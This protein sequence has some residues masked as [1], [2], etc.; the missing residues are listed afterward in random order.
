MSRVDDKNEERRAEEARAAERRSQ[1]RLQRE[2]RA[3]ITAFD[4]A[5]AA[6]APP[7]RGPPTRGGSGSSAFRRALLGDPREAQPSEGEALEGEV[8]AEE[9]SGAASPKAPEGAKA[10][11]RQGG[12]QA[13]PSSA[14]EGSPAA[15]LRWRGRGAPPPPDKYRDASARRTDSET[16]RA[17]VREEGKQRAALGVALR[18]EDR[19]EGDA[20]GRG[21]SEKDDQGEQ[22]M[23]AFKLPPAALMAPP[24]LARPRVEA[25]DGLRGAAREIVEKIVQRV[26]LGTNE[27]GVPEFRME[28]KSS[29]L[30]GLSIRVSA[31]RG[32]RVRAVFSGADR[33]VLASLEEASQELKDALAARGLVLEE[34]LF[35]ESETR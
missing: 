1:E 17:E 26:L 25:N 18:D 3:Q 22:R 30:Q 35:E 21:G 2:R 6:K 23:A 15:D 32:K 31:S 27:Q 16:R 7:S 33:G 29:V 9:A 19:G 14:A 4:R 5:L 10:P 34:L 20:G 11:L 12:P 13:P 28:L 8:L 24:P